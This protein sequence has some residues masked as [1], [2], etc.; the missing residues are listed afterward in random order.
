MGNPMMEEDEDNHVAEEFQATADS[1]ANNVESN[2]SDKKKKQLASFDSLP[3]DF[4]ELDVACKNI[5]K[6][7]PNEIGCIAVHLNDINLLRHCGNQEEYDPNYTVPHHRVAN[8]WS[9]FM[10]S[11]YSDA[12]KEEF[13]SQ[14]DESPMEMD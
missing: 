6:F 4:G 3:E 5:I 8:L 14:L 13:K 12:K 1:I 7:F 2:V 11:Y 9:G 10:E